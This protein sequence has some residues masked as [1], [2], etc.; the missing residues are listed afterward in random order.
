MEEKCVLEPGRTCLG[1]DAVI[2]LE[3]RVEAL[4]K[5]QEGS[6]EFH[7]NFYEWQRG[8]IARDAK[9]DEQIK[10]INQNLDKL[11]KWQEAEKEK[12]GRRWDTMIEKAIGLV[13]AAVIGFVLAR[14]GL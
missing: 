3:M 13:A 5:W 9:L 14:L 1:K 6:R 8:Q 10:T 11:V 7:E 12:P 2:K 4:E